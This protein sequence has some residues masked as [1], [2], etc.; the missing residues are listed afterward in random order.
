MEHDSRHRFRNEAVFSFT[1][2]HGNRLRKRK[3][4]EQIIM[5][6]GTLFHFEF[7]AAFV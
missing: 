5:R 6:K 2:N 7:E 1:V 3:D 4:F